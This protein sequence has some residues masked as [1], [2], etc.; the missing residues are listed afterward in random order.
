MGSATG[1]VIKSALRESGRTQ[2]WL[3]RQLHI[4]R[5]QVSRWVTGKATP[6]P[7]H[8]RRIDELLGT[9]IAGLLE[10]ARQGEHDEYDLFLAT[11]M[12]SLRDDDYSE[13]YSQVAGLVATLREYVGSVYWG[14]EGIVSPD[15]FDLSEI[16]TEENVVALKRS[17]AFLFVQFQ[18]YPVSSGALIELGFALALKKPITLFVSRVSVLPYFME[19]IAPIAERISFLPSVRICPVET[20]EKAS[21]LVKKHGQKIFGLVGQ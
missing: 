5:S 3:A 21:Q 16:G 18:P 20:T 19:G 11:P 12:A 2:K 9:R 8:A 15:R 13:R 17:R 7:I 10:E 4:D 6:L 1:E 14:G